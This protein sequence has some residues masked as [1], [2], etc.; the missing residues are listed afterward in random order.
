MQPPVHRPPPRIPS[1]PPADI[2]HSTSGTLPS[3]T[4]SVTVTMV[5]QVEQHAPTREATRSSSYTDAVKGGKRPASSHPTSDIEISESTHPKQDMRSRNMNLLNPNY[6]PEG[7]QLQPPDSLQTPR[8]T[9]S[10]ITPTEVERYLHE[11]LQKPTISRDPIFPRI[12]QC[13]GSARQLP[14]G[15]SSV[16]VNYEDFRNIQQR[17]GIGVC[18]AHATTITKFNLISIR[19]LTPTSKM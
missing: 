5:T 9:Y 13:R 16:K 10:P 1:P 17:N 12:Q 15:T 8:P 3:S 11:Y 7:S 14:P 19:L 18:Q 2:T 6:E 4:P